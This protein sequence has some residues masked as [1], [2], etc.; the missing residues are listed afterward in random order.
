MSY[1]TLD[2]AG[3]AILSHDFGALRG[4]KSPVLAQVDAYHAVK[5]SPFIR[6]MFFTV[7]E[8]YSLFHV[9]LPNAKEQQHKE[10]AIHFKELTADF[11]V[12]ARE[13]P[14]DSDIH[15]SI[16]GGMLRSEN[17][18]SKIRLSLP[19]IV[20]QAVCTSAASLT[21]AVAHIT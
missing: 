7:E 4:Q 2:S 3:K 16:L 9:S 20:T 17:A 15:K 12:K 18:D 8:L 6:L 13:A 5:P 14:E 21:F 1:V 19:E 10:L 11:L